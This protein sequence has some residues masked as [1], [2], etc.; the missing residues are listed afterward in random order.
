MKERRV[1]ARGLRGPRG[2]REK[3]VRCAAAAARHMEAAKGGA[4]GRW[5]Q[6]EVVGQTGFFEA[7]RA[8]ATWA[9]KD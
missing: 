9:F 3:E 1:G 7:F 4:E 2:H 5:S 8:G 6:E